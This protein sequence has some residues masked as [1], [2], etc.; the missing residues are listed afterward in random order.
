LL[1]VQSPE[2]WPEEVA[3]VAQQENSNLSK[4][5][6]KTEESSEE[7]ENEIKMMKTHWF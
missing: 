6:S 5:P 3:Q 7:K 2:Y 1:F 4:N